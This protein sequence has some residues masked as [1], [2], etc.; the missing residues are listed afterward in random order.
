MTFYDK[1]CHAKNPRGSANVMTFCHWYISVKNFSEKT[2]DIDID[3]LILFYVKRQND[4]LI[5]KI[6]F[7]KD[8]AL[9]NM[10]KRF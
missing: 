6:I 2:F 3:I 8:T 10:K 7:M 5:H 1:K 9:D 4:I